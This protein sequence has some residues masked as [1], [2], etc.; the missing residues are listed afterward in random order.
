M[1]LLLAVLSL[2]VFMFSCNKDMEKNDPYQRVDTAMCMQHCKDPYLIPAFTGYAMSEV[3][4]LLLTI[5]KPDGNFNDK[6]GEK[7][8]TMGDTTVMD[9]PYK[10][11]SG[12][13]FSI[14]P[15]SDY[16]VKLISNNR[17]YK[18]TGVSCTKDSQIVNCVIAHHMDCA[19]HPLFVVIDGDTSKKFI[20]KSVIGGTVVQYQ[21]YISK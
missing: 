5:Y 20:V 9:Y 12:E 19:N 10:T 16:I 7:L 21:F 2:A 4:S 13:Y 14:Q 3:D 1:R 8:F 17:Q 11:D 6:T 18:L 15:G